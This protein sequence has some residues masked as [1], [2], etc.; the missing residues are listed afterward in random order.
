[1]AEP[2]LH[3]YYTSL[4]SWRI[5]QAVKAFDDPCNLDHFNTAITS[6]RS[7]NF[8]VDFSDDEAWCGFDLEAD[9]YTS[10]LKVQV[11]RR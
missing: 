8:F 7:Q 9:D 2:S 4:K 3:P 11:G 5:V 1:M 6:A 10:L